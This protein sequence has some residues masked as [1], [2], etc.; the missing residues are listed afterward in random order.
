MN[1]LIE[2]SELRS[3]ARAGHIPMWDQPRE[4]KPAPD[5]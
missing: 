4:F 3:I 1:R 2:G 5:L